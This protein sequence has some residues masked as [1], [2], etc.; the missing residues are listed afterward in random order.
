[1]VVTCHISQ[2]SPKKKN[3]HGVCVCTCMRVMGNWLTPQACVCV[4]MC[5]CVTGNWLTPQ[6]RLRSPTICCLQARDPRKL[7]WLSPHPGL[8]DQETSYVDSSPRIRRWDEVS[9]LNGEKQGQILPS[10][11]S[12]SIHALNRLG[13]AHPHWGEQSI[14]LSPSV[15]ILISPGTH[16]QI[17]PEIMFNLGTV[18]PI[19]WA[20]KISRHK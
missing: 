3:L 16:S 12:Y 8:G 15:L 18:W 2:G 5:M 11:A 9:R 7:G 13:E 17:H 14:F 20:H 4:H 6:W 1:M 10:S 19:R